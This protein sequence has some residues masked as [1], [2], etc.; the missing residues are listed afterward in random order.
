MVLRF[1]F[2]FLH[3]SSSGFPCASKV[4]KRS[5][6]GWAGSSLRGGACFSG[7]HACVLS[8]RDTFMMSGGGTSVSVS[9]SDS[10]SIPQPGRATR[11]SSV[12]GEALVF[13]ITTFVL[14]VNEN[15]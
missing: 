5:N 1:D 4:S 7:M 8:S 6:G 9:V 10:E 14:S 15:Y 11:K 12:L 2:F 3:S 13:M